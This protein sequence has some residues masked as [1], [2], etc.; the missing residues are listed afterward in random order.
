[1]SLYVLRRRSV[2]L[3]L[4]ETKKFS[5]QATPSPERPSAPH[6]FECLRIEIRHF[7]LPAAVLNGPAGWQPGTSPRLQSVGAK[8]TALLET[9]KSVTVCVSVPV[10]VLVS[11]TENAL[12]AVLAQ[13]ASPPPWSHLQSATIGRLV[14]GE[15]AKAVNAPVVGSIVKPSTADRKST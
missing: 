2:Q 9:L 14:N 11:R 3:L 13:N 5:S 1:M 7:N 4:S 8:G 10:E 15:F 6:L 12:V